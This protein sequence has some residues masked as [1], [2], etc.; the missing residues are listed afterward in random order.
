MSEWW[1][2]T[3]SD[4]LMFSAR[5]YYRLFELYNREIWPAQIVTIA[6]GIVILVCLQRADAWQGRIVAAILAGG[7]LLAR[8]W[9]GKGS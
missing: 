9:R 4:L 1:T 5:T 2:Y 7:A 3:L 6:L 8:S